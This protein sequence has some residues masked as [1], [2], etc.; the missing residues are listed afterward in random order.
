MLAAQDVA[1]YVN[2]GVVTLDQR[3]QVIRSGADFTILLYRGYHDIFSS[4]L[5]QKCR[6]IMFANADFSEQA[7]IAAK[8]QWMQ[9]LPFSVSI[10]SVSGIRVIPG[11]L[12]LY[13][14]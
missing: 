4:H 13:D 1:Q 7:A 5:F 2:V 10:G 8:S 12:D 6:V 14:C 9:M 11:S 3:T